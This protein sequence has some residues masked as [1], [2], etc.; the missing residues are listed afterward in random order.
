MA[1][2]QGYLYKIWRLDKKHKI[3]IRSTVHAYKTK[4]AQAEGA[5]VPSDV[6]FQNAYTL[7]EY[8]SNKTNWKTNLE[9]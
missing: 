2:R 9:L 8:E 1:V 6:I 7:I 5:P 4:T 3:C